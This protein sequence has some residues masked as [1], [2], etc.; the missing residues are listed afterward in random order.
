MNNQDQQPEEPERIREQVLHDLFTT[1]LGDEPPSGFVAAD[2]IRRAQFEQGADGRGR[3]AVGR[4]VVVW[5]GVAAVT[6]LVVFG[7][8]RLVQQP[9]ESNA[10]SSSS[11]SSSSSASSSGAPTAAGSLA[12]GA[13]S[14]RSSSSSASGGSATDPLTT[15]A[16]SS[17]GPAGSE[18]AG[19]AAGPGYDQSSSSSSASSSLAG[20][21]GSGSPAPVSS[22]SSAASSGGASGGE[23]PASASEL[24]ARATAAAIAF[25][26]ALP[27]GSYSAPRVSG[28]RSSSA[29]LVLR[30]SDGRSNLTLT[31]TP[32]AAGHCPPASEC[33]AVPGYTDVYAVG[34]VGHTSAMRFVEEP[35]DLRITGVT[36]SGLSDSRLAAAGEQ[37]VTALKR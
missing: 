18:A 12:G 36:G 25:R 31:V 9:S 32:H 8:T 35:W 26:A 13:G 1:A 17:A 34:P 21:P 3:T 19:S 5:I 10:G 28:C 37:A 4:R 30:G 23:Q 15:A 33:R 24:C 29:A 20:A 27:S 6:A 14:G 22:A 16:A 11:S 2:V 7:V